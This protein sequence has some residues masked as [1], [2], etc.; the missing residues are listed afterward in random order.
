MAIYSEEEDQNVID[1]K[2]QDMPN[3]TYKVAFEIE[4]DAEDPLA[5]AK[6]VQEWLQNPNDNW[7]FYVQEENK[8]EINSV[9][10]DEDE[11]W[12]VLPADNYYPI[13]KN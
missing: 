11:S 2:K 10:L 9:D 12:A 13:I 8:K 6:K 7:Q 5:A 1:D 4:V 3:K